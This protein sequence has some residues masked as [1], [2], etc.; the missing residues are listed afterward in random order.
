[1]NVLKIKKSIDLK[2]GKTGLINGENG[3]GMGFRKMKIGS[4]KDIDYGAF[5]LIFFL[6]LI[7]VYYAS[8]VLLGHNVNDGIQAIFWSTVFGWTIKS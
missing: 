3:K 4:F 5:L 8:F 1:M 6:G 2:R 7:V